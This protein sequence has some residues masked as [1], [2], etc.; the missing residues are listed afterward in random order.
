MPTEAKPRTGNAIV[1]VL[2]HKY[3][4]GSGAHIE[5]VYVDEDRARSDYDLLTEGDSKYSASEW[6]LDKTQF[7]ASAYT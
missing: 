3:G 4:D 2:W 7:I 6:R 1:W 5:R